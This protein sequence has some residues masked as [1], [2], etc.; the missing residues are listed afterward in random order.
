MLY[1]HN[2][3][4]RLNNGSFRQIETFIASVP[5][6]VKKEEIGVMVLAPLVK[7]KLCLF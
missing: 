1:I 3:L 6:I 2:I 4:Y 5:V 7:A